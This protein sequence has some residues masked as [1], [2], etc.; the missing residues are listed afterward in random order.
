MG[1]VSTS[2]H[3]R[4][5]P[6]QGYEMTIRKLLAAIIVLLLATFV[7]AD[8]A[9]P[10]AQPVAQPKSL[11]ARQAEMKFNLDM[12]KLDADYQQKVNAIKQAYVD[13]LK[14]ALKTLAKQDNADPDEIA[15]LSARIK[16]VEATVQNPAI[17]KI[18]LKLLTGRWRD[19]FNT[20]SRIVIFRDDHSIY[21]NQQHIGFWI[22]EGSN[23][24]EMGFGGGY[25]KDA[26]SSDLRSMEGY[27]EMDGHRKHDYTYLGK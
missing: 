13:N 12:Q 16:E 8:D 22:Q 6:N 17:P 2:Y 10:D 25:Q 1:G 18:Q 9:T 21:C 5:S 14:N 15:K 4:L 7:H 27:N 26:L 23:V 20:G 11:A 24:Y 19:V 3:R